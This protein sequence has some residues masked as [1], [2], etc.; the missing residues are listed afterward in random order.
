L[1]RHVAGKTGTTQDLRDLWFIGYTPDMVAGVWLG[2]DDFQPMGKKITSAG[3]TVPFWTDF[4]TEAGKYLP[5]R[6]FPVP[7]GITF[8]KIDADTGLLALPTTAHAVLEAFKVGT[9]PNEFT[10]EIPDET[11]PEEIEVTE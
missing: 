11:E 2:Y 6:D 5:V 7:P 3:V 10:P 9:V 1:G 8:A 4:M